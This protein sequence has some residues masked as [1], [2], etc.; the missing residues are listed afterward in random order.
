MA[1][2]SVASL[3][4]VIDTRR[5]DAD[6]YRPEYLRITASLSWAP[7]LKQFV[8][9]IIHPAEFSRKYSGDGWKVVRTQNVR[10]LRMEFDSNEVFLSEKVASKLNKNH[11]RSGDILITR[12]GAN[13][14][15]CSLFYAEQQPALATSHTFIVRANEKI[16]STYL[17]LFLNTM[18][19]RQLIDR[20]M[21]GSS[22]PEIAPRFLLRL[23]IPR[24]AESI[25][26]ELAMFVRKAYE[27]RKE[28]ISL[29]KQAHHLLESKLGLDK[30]SFQK[31]VGYTA[32]FSELEQS[33]RAD[34]EFFH[35][36]YESFL[37]AVKGYR[38]GWTTLKQLTDRTLPN[39]NGKGRSED[40]KYIEIGDINIGDGSYT[41]S[42]ILAT[43]LPAN[44]KIILN[45]GE[46]LISQ[47][48]PTRG[49]IVIIDDALSYPTICSGAFY[50]CTAKEQNRREAVWLYLRIIKA[51]FEKYCGGTSYPT[52]DSNYVAKFPVPIFQNKL[53]LRVRELVLKSK[54]AKGESQRLITLA[55]TRVEQLIEEVVQS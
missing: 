19:G 6:H 15:Q 8:Q 32:R 34:A 35:T 31:P 41:S 5:I 9:E 11:L 2:W 4:S 29:Y 49:A 7:P 1:V 33:R 13:F 54:A 40:Y 38:G 52:I 48:R 39:Y 12:T 46:I 18:Q 16:D 45:G 26:A 23:P 42:R 36:K 20:G 21:Y 28:S 3:Q 27:L 22:Q 24:F 51:I 17:A 53:A 55:K 10:P 14:G 43:Q 37:S 44:A 50:V 25:E 47:V 30:L